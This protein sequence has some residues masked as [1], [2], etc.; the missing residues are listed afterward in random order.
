MTWPRRVSSCRPRAAGFLLKGMN[1]KTR[2]SIGALA[3]WPTLLLLLLPLGL[4]AADAAKGSDNGL[5]QFIQN[6]EEAPGPNIGK[7]L[8]ANLEVKDSAGKSVEL[9][10]LLH[11]PAVVVKTLNG[12]PPCSALTDYLKTHGKEYMKT[13]GVQIVVL[14]LGSNSPDVTR[15]SYPDGVQVLHTP[16]MLMDSLIGGTTV[17]A[18]YFFDKNLTLVGTHSGLYNDREEAITAT[19]GFP[20]AASAQ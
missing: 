17:P 15:G 3:L 19:L 10:T 6:Q 20:K 7:T 16:S 2:A 18:V 13:H 4:Q 1:M 11:G 5:A 9:R 8:P 12:C 14:T